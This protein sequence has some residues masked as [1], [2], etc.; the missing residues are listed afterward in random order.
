M[1]LIRVGV[2]WV[3]SGGGCERRRNGSEV[4]EERN[5]RKGVEWREKER[6][7][8]KTGRKIYLK[9]PHVGSATLKSNTPGESTILKHLMVATYW[10][11]MSFT[12]VPGWRGRFRFL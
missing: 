4:E 10:E 1:R 2:S 3:G 7:K 9:Y 5:N 6:G 11:R 8:G 12:S